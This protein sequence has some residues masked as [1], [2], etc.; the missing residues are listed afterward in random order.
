M[1]FEFFTPG[2]N[3][4]IKNCDADFIIY[5]TEHSGIGIE[6]IKEMSS[7]CYGLDLYPIV[8]VNGKEYNSIAPFLDAGAKGIM[9]PNIKNAKEAKNIVEF[10]KYR[11]LGKRGIAFNVSH[12]D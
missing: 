7:Y 3:K 11:P 4:I 1:I 6:K 8:R 5:D 12:D 2:I 10:S 9:V